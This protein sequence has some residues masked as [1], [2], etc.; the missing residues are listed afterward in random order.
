MSSYRIALLP[1]DGIGPECMEATYRVLGHMVEQIAGLDLGFTSHR[2]GAELYR[3]TGETLPAAVLEDCLAADAVLLS[4]IGLPDVRYPDGTEVQPTMMVGL[5]RALAVHS[6]VRPV[7]LYRGAP[8]VL[9]DTGPG[10]DFVIIRENL[11]GLF[12]SFGGGSK[13]GDE[14]AT[15]T[16]VVT[17]KGTSQVSDFAFRLAQRRKGRPVD[18]KKM[19][20]CVDKANVFQSMAFFRKVFFDVAKNYPDIQA[21]AVYVDA[22]SLYMVQN[23]W[24]F[25]VL[26]ME[27]QFGDILSDLGAGLVGG[28]GVGPSAEIGEDHGLFQ[29][30]HGTAP[31][32]AGKNVANP[33]ATILSAAMMLDWLG[34]KHNDA[35]CLRAAVDL[36]Q[37]VEK[38]IAD[39]N[40]ITPDMGGNASTSQV[41]AAVCDALGCDAPGSDVRSIATPAR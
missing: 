38:V 22:M 15:D 5:R 21:D 24:D 23:P 28:L 32:L 10:I 14:V 29:P 36:E 3:D 13:V 41:A 12:A 16:L 20:T 11:E 39:G 40:V 7:K 27:N 31:Q 37:A 35:V 4:A 18:G 33:L 25:D 19:V 8:C 17:R 6:A 9:K 30:S 2:A 26:V 1:G 34:D